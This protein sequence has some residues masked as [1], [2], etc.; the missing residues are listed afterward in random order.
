MAQKLTVAKLRINIFV[1][2]IVFSSLLML[3]PCGLLLRQRLADAGII[4]EIM[5][6]LAGLWLPALSCF[7]AFWFSEGNERGAED[8]SPTDGQRIGSFA[9]TFLYFMICIL[10][11]SLTLFVQKYDYDPVTNEPLG[12]LLDQSTA[13]VVSW[14]QLLSPVLLAPL[15][16]LTGRVPQPADPGASPNPI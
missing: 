16:Y 8:V 5:K 12:A 6:L 4:F 1:L 14:I 11:V 2:W 3:L 15:G 10:V 9:L 13:S 7:S